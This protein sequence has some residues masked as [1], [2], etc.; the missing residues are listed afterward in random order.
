MQILCWKLNFDLLV[1]VITPFLMLSV[2][3]NKSL[4]YNFPGLMFLYIP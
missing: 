1:T 3:T 4:R 2:H